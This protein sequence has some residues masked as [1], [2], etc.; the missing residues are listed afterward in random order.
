MLGL[1]II[2]KSE[3]A[4]LKASKSRLISAGQSLS[5]ENE[6]LKMRLDLALIEVNRYKP[7]QGENGRFV[8]KNKK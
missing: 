1:T 4:E 7:K 8:R 5:A 6:T 3:L 2:K